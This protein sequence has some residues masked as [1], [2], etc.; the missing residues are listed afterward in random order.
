[1][2]VIWVQKLR[3]NNNETVIHV[4]AGSRDNYRSYWATFFAFRKT[5][6]ERKLDDKVQG[7]SLIA[8]SN[9]CRFNDPVDS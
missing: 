1:M 9:I 7:E 4:A 2:K 8:S 3:T 6:Q 5:G